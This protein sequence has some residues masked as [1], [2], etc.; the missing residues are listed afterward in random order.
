MKL[1]E[2][3]DKFSFNADARQ[4][5][6]QSFVDYLSQGMPINNIVNM[7]SESIVK[8]NSKGQMFLAR[9]LDDVDLQ[10][11][12]GVEF[13]TA[14]SKW[15]PSNEAMSIRAGMRSGDPVTGMRNTIDSLK[16]S[17]AMLS[18]IVSKLSYPGVLMLALVGL[19]YFFSVVI[20]P[21]IADVMDPEMWPP[22]SKRLYD[23]ALFV[24]ND[25]WIV[26][27]VVV[28]IGLFINRTIGR[29]TGKPRRILDKIPPYS[30]Y[31]AFHGANLLISIGALMR[32]GIPFVE[33]LKES[34]AM[35]SPYLKWHLSMMLQNLSE[36]RDIGES[37]DTGLL[38]S[39]MMVSVHM[40]TKNADFQTAIGVIGVQA[41][42]KSVETIAKIAGLINALVLL[43]VASYIGWV[44]YAFFSVTNALGQSV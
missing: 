12:S 31:K 17:S 7:L 41:V 14:L 9:I 34:Q 22:V 30:F 44:Y 33:S 37:F 11:S 4:R 21:K 16:S 10:M 26:V 29:L 1:Q 8:A 5:V 28:L 20:I 36:G 32:S 35:A 40:M 2:R 38:S 24:Q 19:I 42:D 18:T 27:T 25:W 23:M 15:V 39:E 6:Y 13:S 43:G 3:L